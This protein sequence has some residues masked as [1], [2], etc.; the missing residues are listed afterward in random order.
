MPRIVIFNPDGSQEVE[1]P[2]TLDDAREEAVARAKDRYA[3]H[4]AEGM[5]WQGRP[6]QINGA[7][8]ANISAMML[9]VVAQV[10]LTPGFAWRMGDN[11]FLPMDAA[12]MAAMAVAAAN[13]IESLRQAMWA[14]VDAARAAETNEAADA[15]AAPPP[16]PPTPQPEPQPEPEA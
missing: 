1:D 12:G 14:D 13:H 8:V 3:G 4:I 5:T 11:S 2:R 6:L 16:P 7:A 9:R 15:I 10:P